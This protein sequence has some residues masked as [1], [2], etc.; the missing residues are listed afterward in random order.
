MQLDPVRW[1]RLHCIPLACIIAEVEAAARTRS[2]S[3]G[4]G[5]VVKVSCSSQD[6]AS[7]A[8]GIRSA[9]KHEPT[10][11]SECSAECAVLHKQQPDRCGW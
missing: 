2:T 7:V 5:P 10:V 1:C 8:M 3:A 9:H 11:I 6:A 4:V